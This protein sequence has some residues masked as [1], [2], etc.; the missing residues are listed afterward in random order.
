MRGPRL[1]KRQI[2]EAEQMIA[3]GSTIADAARAVGRN[4]NALY[5]YFRRAP[6]VVADKT[7]I[8][9]HVLHDRD[10]RASLRHTTLTAAICGDPLR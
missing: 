2:V 6:V 9:A 5:A 8:P 3:G 10:R 4:A 1:T 7:E